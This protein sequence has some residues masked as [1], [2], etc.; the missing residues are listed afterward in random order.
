MDYFGKLDICFCRDFDIFLSDCLGTRPTFLQFDLR[1]F[2]FFSCKIIFVSSFF[3]VRSHILSHSKIPPIFLWFCL[4]NHPFIS[5]IDP[6][7]DLWI[8]IIISVIH[9]YQTKLLALERKCVRSKT[10]RA[11]SK[12]MF[13]NN[14]FFI[15]QPYQLTLPTSL[16]NGSLSP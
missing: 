6:C 9:C 7:S 1:V 12:R 13:R 15:N 2:E 8:Y 11:L 16:N 4:S 3:H 10:R 14:F 5:I